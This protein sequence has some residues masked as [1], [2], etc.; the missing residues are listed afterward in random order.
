MREFEMKYTNTYYYCNMITNV[1][2]SMDYLSNIAQFLEGYFDEENANTFRFPKDSMLHQFC[3]WFVDEVVWES[4]DKELD[5]IDD[6]I[7]NLS[8]KNTENFKKIFT[9]EY[10]FW[11]DDKY[12]YLELEYIIQEFT[13]EKIK[14]LDWLLRND[15]EF[16][17]DAA[18]EYFEDNYELCEKAITGISDEMFYLLFQNREFLLNFNDMVAS[19]N[20]FRMERINIPK[21]VKRAVF[22]RDKGRCVF[23]GKDLSAKYDTI[24]DY[25]EQY[26]HI[27]PLE[28]HGINDVSNIQLTCKKCNLKKLV[29]A[30]TNNV[31][32]Y[33]YNK[34]N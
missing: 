13:G 25:E 18:R 17:Q 29:T 20:Y 33:W 5:I 23:C 24:D 4:M 10:R 21:W 27:V 8:E 34:E 1:I 3:T 16:V 14:F 6:K 11:T 19:F 12:K 28:E 7:K 31:Y 22:F 9:D 15:F 2:T 32:T 30:A 26:D